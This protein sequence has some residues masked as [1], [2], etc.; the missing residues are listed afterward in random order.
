MKT[1]ENKKTVEGKIKENGIRTNAILLK[2][3]LKD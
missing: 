1:N 2:N 3:A